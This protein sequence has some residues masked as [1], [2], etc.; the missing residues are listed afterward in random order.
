MTDLKI[1][2]LEAQLAKARREKE[3]RESF[4]KAV[5]E[6]SK[7]DLQGL[8]DGLIAM[9]KARHVRSIADIE[10]LFSPAVS[11]DVVAIGVPSDVAKDN[12]VPDVF[13]SVGVESEQGR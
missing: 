12:S 8:H 7:S 6:Q 2:E 13:K 4:K 3:E 5:A 1:E 11:D 9:E 10:A